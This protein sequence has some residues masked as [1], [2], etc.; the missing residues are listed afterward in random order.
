MPQ[1]LIIFASGIRIV[2]S[3]IAAYT[4]L[5]PRSIAIWQKGQTGNGTPEVVPERFTV[6]EATRIRDHWLRLLD[7]AV[8]GQWA[9]AILDL[10][11]TISEEY[12]ENGY[13]SIDAT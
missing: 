3:E 5:G 8:S 9:G 1:P 4:D 6:E 2:G 13:I 12:Q 11:A 7:R 10:R